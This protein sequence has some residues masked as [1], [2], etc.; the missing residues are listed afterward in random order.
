MRIICKYW[1]QGCSLHTS[2]LAQPKSQY[3]EMH[4]WVELDVLPW[5]LTIKGQHLSWY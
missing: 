2:G 1:M 4:F 5:V 3:E